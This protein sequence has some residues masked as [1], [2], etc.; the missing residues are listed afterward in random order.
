[1]RQFLKTLLPELF[2]R[3]SIDFFQS[4]TQRLSLQIVHGI[5]TRKPNDALAM[6]GKGEAPPSSVLGQVLNHFNGA[7][8]S[9]L[10]GGFGHLSV[11][12]S[13]LHPT[14][15]RI[16]HL[17]F[18]GALKTATHFDIL[19]RD[20]T[21]RIEERIVQ[22][23]GLCQ[24][25]QD[26]PHFCDAKSEEMQVDV[27]KTDPEW[28]K[29]WFN[30]KA[31]HVL[32][33]HRSEFEATHAVSTLSAQGVLGQPA[34]V[35]DAGCGA[36]RHARALAKEGWSV[37]AFDLSEASI[38]EARAMETSNIAYHC[39]DLRDL[40]SQ[41]KWHASFDLVTNFFT[42]L[43][44][45]D[46]EAEHE[47]VVKVFVT[48]LKPGRKLLVDFLNVPQVEAN[49]VA[50]E[51]VSKQGTMF[52]IHRRIHE[53]WV[54]KSIQ[55]EW[56]GSPQHHVERVRALDRPHLTELLM[57]FGLEVRHIWGDYDL[58]EWTP[59][60]P[61]CMILAELPTTLT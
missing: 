23:H 7:S 48:A 13:M 44:Y 27:W 24:R 20:A 61:R 60:S 8:K 16:H 35:L 1:M 30:T 43:G 55:F 51:T 18:V 31:Y 15:D 6:H 17:A 28:F 39:L 41:T 4:H 38:H 3:Q 19:E 42:S 59:S 26:M 50:S 21:G 33:G 40:L 46:E 37:E 25:T 47:A 53:G 45:F 2:Q 12:Q 56:E 49:L 58:N 11:L 36:G 32:Y 22:R 52:H 54:E 29:P 57:R 10:F 14:Q 34:R 9:A 5:D